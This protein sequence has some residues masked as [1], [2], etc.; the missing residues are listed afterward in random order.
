M[1]D[2]KFAFRQLLKNPGF[3]AVA[4]LTLA[5]GIGATTAIFS[6]V[7]AVMLRPLPFPESDRLLWLSEG[8]AQGN[9][10]ISYPNFTDWQA[11]QTVFEHMGVYNSGSYNLVGAG[12]PRNLSAARMTAGTFAVLRAQPELGRVFSPD[13]DRP[14]AA[15]VIVLSHA[16]WLNQFGG[17]PAILNRTVRLDGAACTV[18]GVMPAGFVFP[19]RVD[20]WVPLGPLTGQWSYQARNNH[21][22]LRGVARLRPGV[23]LAQARTEMDTIAK[24][25]QQ[26][27]PDTGAAVFLEPLLNN[28]VGNAGRAL[29]TLLGAVGLVLLIACANVANLLLAR[30]AARQKEMAMRAALGAGRWQIVRQLLTESLLLA[31]LGGTLG[32]LLARGCLGLILT[33]G[34]GAIP[35]VAEIHMDV[36]VL[37][38]TLLTAL[39]TGLLFGLVPAWQASRPALQ[40][41]I[42]DGARGTTGGRSRLR[43]GL[44][45]AEVSLTLMLLIGAGLLLHSFQ[46]LRTV[47]PG[48]SAEQ[49]L[50]FRVQLP[51]RKYATFEQQN[52]FYQTLVE[53]LEA[54][55][56][57]R[58]AGVA[59]RSPLDPENSQTGYQLEGQ[60]ETKP[61]DGLNM[62]LTY[63]SPDYFRAMGMPLLRGRAFTDQ[64]NREHLR[65]TG[66]EG[67]KDAGAKVI[68]VDEDFVRRHWPNEDPIGKQ[69]RLPWGARAD[70]P[71]LTVVGVVP[72]VKVFSMSEHGG[73]VQAYLPAW[74]LPGP[75]RAVVV[76]TAVAPETLFAAVQAQVS[77]LDPEQPVSNL[78]TVAELRDDS[79]SPQRL[80][81]ALLG[82]FGAV[83]LALAAI[84]LYGVLAYAVA[85][86]RRELGVRMALGAQRS[87]VLGLVIG[88]GMRLVALGVVLGLAGAVALTRIMDSLLFDV[89]AMDPLT[90]ASVP[91][92]LTGVALLACWLPARRA[93]RVDPMAALR[94]E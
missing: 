73:V 84:G 75:N 1:N 92:L 78:R 55:P 80:N 47:S 30:A 41:V 85:Q 33:L 48:F 72:H 32:L 9:Y 45:V 59:T 93:T 86:R 56:G 44:I 14:G 89:T 81:L 19:T 79:L 13:E 15:P 83:A 37:A 24:R 29:W 17:D 22:G 28:V 67:N 31:L 62:D 88:D 91:L 7:S 57:V 2:L 65:G 6:V 35:R 38:F 50:S 60:S 42:T 4:V 66:R 11:Q 43:Q 25:L 5:L 18:V 87:N 36:G 34:S 61:D 69:V 12:D 58:A 10:P 64:D 53:K 77:S 40:T 71:V 70:N 63:A 54:L 20:A 51:V 90:F 74:Q 68:I 26:Q 76:K 21:P 3:T 52:A 27:H 39:T 8:N 49:A 16:L 23:S 94:A 82:F 46:N